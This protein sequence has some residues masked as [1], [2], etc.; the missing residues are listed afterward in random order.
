MTDFVEE[1]FTVISPRYQHKLSCIFHRKHSPYIDNQNREHLIIICH[2]YM[3]HKNALFLPQLSRDISES[4]AN[5]FHSVRFDFHGCG[6]STGRDLWDY[7]G[8]EDEAKDDL[9]YVVEYLRSSSKKYFIRALIG[10]SRAGTTVLLYSLYYD[11]IPIVVNIAGRY[12][13]ERGIK[14]RFSKKQL[15]ELEKN[16]SFII[17]TNDNGNFRITKQAIERRKNLDL[18]QIEKIRQAKVLNIWGDHDNVMPGD[19][20]YLF[21][22]QL[23]NTKKSEMII[24]SDADHCFTGKEQQLINIVQQWIQ[25]SID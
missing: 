9:R 13:L 18:S 2:G 11:D 7:G 20:I 21:H 25:Q 16:G 6:E 12:R 19:E 24:V 17:Y 23:K 10:H 3:S 8:Y 5:Q 1:S 15:D 4:T 22:E 14:E